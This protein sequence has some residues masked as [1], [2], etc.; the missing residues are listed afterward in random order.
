MYTQGFFIQRHPIKLSLDPLLS[1]QR[2]EHMYVLNEQRN[3][4]FLVD[5]KRCV[6]SNKSCIRSF[7]GCADLNLA[8]LCWV[9]C[10][11]FS[12]SNDDFLRPISD[13]QS[14]HVTFW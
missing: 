1:Y 6:S 2:E 12:D 5:T 11:K 13:Q 8:G 7:T 14:L 4:Y 3:S 9:S 10:R